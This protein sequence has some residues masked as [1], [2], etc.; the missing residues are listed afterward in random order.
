MYV[1]L[2]VRF[3]VII[4]DF[5]K[6]GKEEAGTFLSSALVFQI[7]VFSRASCLSLARR[8]VI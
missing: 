1:A 4:L 7:Q 2:M 8:A 6:Q 3:Q 5:Y